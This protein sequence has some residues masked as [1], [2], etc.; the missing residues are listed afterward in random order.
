MFFH[1]IGRKEIPMSTIIDRLAS[2]P[3]EKRALIL[4]RLQAGT[5]TPVTPRPAQEVVSGDVPFLPLQKMLLNMATAFD[6]NYHHFN[7]SALLEVEHP[8]DPALVERV[9][10]HLL[11]HHDVL[12]LRIFQDESGEWRQFIADDNEKAPVS[13][14]DLSML[15]QSEQHA[16]L[17]AHAARL[18]ESLNLSQGPI[19]RVALFN[20]GEQRPGRM[21]LIVHHMAADEFSMRILLEDFATAY[22]QLSQGQ[23]LRLPPKT[24]SFKERNERIIAYAQS[25]ALREEL[26]YWLGLPWKEVAPLPVDYAEGLYESPQPRRI[27]HL[28][29]KEETH[30]LRRSIPGPGGAHIREMLVTALMQV[31]TSWSGSRT[32]L[33]A[34]LTSG[35]QPLFADMDLSRTAG[36][37]AMTPATVLQLPDTTSAYERLRSVTEQLQR[38]PNEG[39]GYS[40]LNFLSDDEEIISACS[41]HPKP[42]VAFNYLGQRF[43][44]APFRPAPESMGRVSRIPNLWTSGMQVIN[45]E[46]VDQRLLMRWEYSENVYR[47]STIEGHIDHF[48]EAL[49]SLTQS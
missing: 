1:S 6:I 9:V 28:F 17:E 18:Q 36:W 16:A 41:E 5:H 27:E 45:M 39:I 25:A 26:P 40:L 15:P 22:R 42:M 33:F 30:A 49:R 7:V 47:H 8:L 29:S 34:L 46:M 37:L 20:F 2:L 31:F 43:T 12:R 21:L 13:T 38:I 32:H 23:P 14:I 24:T 10:R 44:P 19:L 35:R 4:R 11:H 3:A 48:R